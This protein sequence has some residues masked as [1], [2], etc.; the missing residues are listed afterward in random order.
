MAGALD[1]ST[2]RK[3]HMYSRRG[4]DQLL[5]DAAERVPPHFVRCQTDAL[6][7][8]AGRLAR[9]SCRG[10]DMVEEDTPPRTPVPE[11]RPEI[12]PEVARE[13][14]EELQQGEVP[15][16]PQDTTL[17]PGVRV[18][19]EREGISWRREAL[20]T[21][22]RYLA[23][24]AQEHPDIEEPVPMEP[25]REP[26]QAK[27]EARAEI[28]ERGVHRTR[29]RAPAGETGEER[30]ARVGKCVEEIWEE[31]QRLEAAGALPD[32]PPDVP[33]KPCGVT[34]MW[35]KFWAQYGEELAV[36][37]RAGLETAR[38]ADGYLD[39]KFRF[40]AK[41]SFQRYLMLGD[42]LAGRKVKFGNL[43]VC[44]EAVE[45]EIRELRTQTASQAATIQEMRQQLQ[46]MAA[47]IERKAPTRVV[48]WTESKRYGIQGEAVQGLFGQPSTADPSHE[49]SIG[50]VILELEE[51]KA[52]REAEREAFGFQAPT[53][54][55][56]QAVTSSGPAAESV[57]VQARD[58]PRTTA[59]EPAPGSNEGSMD[60]L[61]EA[62]N[63]MQEGASM[64]MS[65]QRVE[66]PREGE[67]MVTMEGVFR[68]RP[69]RLYTPEYRPEGVRMKIE[70]ST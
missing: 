18:E 50:K 64:F 11:S 56:T 15:L 41:T 29:G 39:R 27:R 48:D 32:Q 36:P 23:A 25:P 60:V 57:L 7:S 16:P 22:N 46:D 59:S 5:R 24:H 42:E 9:T 6:D 38:S 33:P 70:P 34:E 31:R 63:T 49:L 35:D 47:R 52:K 66:E 17:S 67:M 68:G 28:P 40:P 19:M 20:S 14:W 43:G 13:A 26:R 58:G 62:I 2:L 4:I 54:L 44:L 3:L 37:E 30:R 61:L 12:V 10:G 45:A 55:A 53:E 8:G 69:Q 21:I 65:E 1:R 51:A